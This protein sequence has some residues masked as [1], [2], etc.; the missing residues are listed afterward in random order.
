MDGKSTPMEIQIQEAID[1]G[2]LTPDKLEGGLIA[3]IQEEMSQNERPANMKLVNACEDLLFRIHN[4]EYISNKTESLARVKA[5]LAQ[6][7]RK[8]KTSVCVL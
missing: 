3:L 2:T 8:T 7:L 5:K 1:S 6:P 4:H